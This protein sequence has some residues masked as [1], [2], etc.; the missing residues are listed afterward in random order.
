MRF[1]R[2]IPGL[3]ATAL[4]RRLEAAQAIDLTDTNLTNCGITVSLE[5]LRA[6]VQPASL[7]YSPDPLGA[8]GARAEL[9]RWLSPPCAADDLVLTASTSEAYA[10]LFKV[11][12]EPGDHVA[13]PVPGYPLLRHLAELENLHVRAYDLHHHDG[14]WVDTAQVDALLRAGARA[15]IAVSPHNPTGTMLSAA[16]ADELL[17]LCSTHGVPLICDEVFWGYDHAGAPPAPLHCVRADRGDVLIS[18]RGLSKLGFPQLKLAWMRLGG[19]PTR[20]AALRQALG[21]VLDATLSLSTPVQVALGPLLG[22]ATEF[23]AELQRLLQARREGVADLASA[24]VQR[25]HADAGFYAV[26]RLACLDEEAFVLRLAEEFGVV[27]HPG[28]FYDFSEPGVLVFSLVAPNFDAGL[29]RLRE[30]LSTLA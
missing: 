3:E 20:C 8:K 18:L 24:H 11:L 25:M 21:W 28:F 9:G 5:V 14:W 16:Q 23:Q 30:G 19:E 27:V 10:A 1:S 4:A 17:A 12:C 7:L 26:L 22:A 15:V 2:R 13:V 6:L 29:S